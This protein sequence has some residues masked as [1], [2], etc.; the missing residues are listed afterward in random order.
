MPVRLEIRNDPTEADRSAILKPLRAHNRAQAGDPQAESFA[1]L[2][3][4]EH[5][6]EVL[7]GLWG[8]VF[9]R[10]LF[11]E[12]LAV[13]EQTSG[14]GM[15]ARLMQMAEQLARDKGCVGIWLDTFSFQ[16]PGFYEKQGFSR[17]GQLED[18]PPGRQRFYYQKRLM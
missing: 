17:F 9:Y 4:D 13:P 5:S 3:R 12:L 11:I 15:G 8:E 6:D 10:W 18:F 7:G 14:Q 16:A 2:V 1:L